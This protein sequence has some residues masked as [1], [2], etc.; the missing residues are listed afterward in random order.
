VT[1]KEPGAHLGQLK[2][3]PLSN[4]LID[5]VVTKYINRQMLGTGNK[6]DALGCTA[7]ANKGSHHLPLGGWE[8]ETE[9]F[10]HSNVTHGTYRA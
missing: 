6:T 5:E 8:E 1:P 7:E 2:C 3:D 9:S 10:T 4:V